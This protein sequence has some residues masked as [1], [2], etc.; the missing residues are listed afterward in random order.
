MSVNKRKSKRCM[1]GAE[2]VGVW[3]GFGFV[4]GEGK[5]EGGGGGGG[6]RNR[7]KKGGRKM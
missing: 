5:G 1:D 7:Q 2:I 6:R 3:G 4:E